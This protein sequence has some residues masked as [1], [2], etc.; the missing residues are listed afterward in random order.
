MSW[1]LF[2]IFEH[3]IGNGNMQRS[4]INGYMIAT[5]I[6]ISFNL[7]KINNNKILW[8][9]DLETFET[10]WILSKH[11]N[12]L[13]WDN[14]FIYTCYILHCTHPFLNTYCAHKWKVLQ[15]RKAVQFAVT[16]L[17]MHDFSILLCTEPVS[18][19]VLDGRGRVWWPWPC[20]SLKGLEIAGIKAGHTGIKA[21]N[22][23]AV[24]PCGL[25][26]LCDV[27]LPKVFFVCQMSFI[28]QSLFFYLLLYAV[29]STFDPK[30]C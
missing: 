17:D 23:G 4:Q 5:C 7:N 22:E 9:L 20:S 29:R 8:H 24:R 10:F 21:V 1:A 3:F 11:Y 16:L 25:L 27:W 30:P 14:F 2:I 6:H 19:F 28:G 13:L 15:L 26:W 12:N 18:L